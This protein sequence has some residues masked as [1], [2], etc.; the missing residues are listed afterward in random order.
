MR[1][2]FTR[3]AERALGRTRVVQPCI[4]SEFAPALALLPP[5]GSE[6]VGG[7]E[8]VRDIRAPYAPLPSA[9]PQGDAGS[10]PASPSDAAQRKQ[11]V[12][13]EQGP[14]EP[15]SVA[16]D[17]RHPRTWDSA[18][19][20]EAVSGARTGEGGWAPVGDMAPHAASDFDA[21]EA[22]PAPAPR[23]ASAEPPRR[24]VPS[25]RGL[26]PV[27]SPSMREE[28][29]LEPPARHRMEVSGAGSY[30]RPAP[31]RPPYGPAEVFE[32]QPGAIRPGNRPVPEVVRPGPDPTGS[33]LDDRDCREAGPPPPPPVIRV[34]I[35]RVEIRAKVSPA[36]L[37]PRS[38]SVRSGPALSLDK[39]LG[40]RDR[41]ER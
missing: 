4:L 24:E 20:T 32:I 1:D 7:V 38:P 16:L 5:A 26:P 30:A 3:L 29:A 2:F 14:G 41:G 39:Y 8:R 34:T 13:Q 22:S 21:G 35:G 25:R 19:G 9:L 15:V 18:T 31:E 27:S 40:R 37:V 6:L 12:Q 28:A 11:G 33:F 17:V 10:G 36:S 23:P